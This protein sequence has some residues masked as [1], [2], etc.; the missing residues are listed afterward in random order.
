MSSMIKDVILNLAIEPGH[1]PTI[2]YAVSLAEVFG[3][4]LA[5]VAFEY[6]PV[7]PTMLVD[8]VPPEWIDEMRRQADDAAA[9]AVARFE[10]AARRA[11]ISAEALRTNAA[12]SGAADLFGRMARRFDLAI[13]RQAEPDKS[14]PAPLI[15]EAAL[16][17]AG[18]PVLVVPYI[19][20]APFKL[21]RVMVCWDGSGSAARA[22]GDALPFLQRSGTVEVVVVSERGKDDELPGADLATHLARHGVAVE[23]K[24]I[25]APGVDAASALLS[26]A[27]ETAADL[28]VLG[29]YGHSRLREF[30]L[31][32]V[33][34]SI[35]ESMTIPA[36]MA[37]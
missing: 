16:F 7:P 4:H 14:T 21:D 15:I 6:E 28:M 34:R 29:G 31:G 20:N 26:H 1:D 32:G 37:H 2:G 33:T 22:V 24:Q 10:E 23:L 36:L 5:G 8:D 25:V 9:A 3:A 13:V 30:I 35:L 11:E 17:Q 19:Q 27:A 12:F 18:R